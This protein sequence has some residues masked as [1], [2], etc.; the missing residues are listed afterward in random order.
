MNSKIP[1]IFSIDVEEWFHIMEHPAVPGIERWDS[2]Q[3]TL[4]K[5]FNMLLDLCGKHDTAGTCFFL[6]WAARKYPHLVKEA[7]RRGFEVA[8][9]GNNHR[10]I[11]KQTPGEFFEDISSAKKFLEDLTGKTV[12]GYR[13]PGFS[14]TNRTEWAFEKIVEAG[15][16]YDSSV[17]PASRGHGGYI[18][19][20]LGPHR[21][22]TASGDLIEIPISVAGVMGKRV[23]FFGGGYFRLFPYR[24]IKRMTQAI[25]NENRP[26]VFY[27][28]PREIDP[29]HPRLKL[30]VVRNFKSYVNLKKTGVKVEKLLTDF[31]FC[32]FKEWID[33]YFING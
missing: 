6:G 1:N 19:D 16:T 20:N 2:L 31:R 5:S 8:S 24:I 17:F 18:T 15:F 9:H 26:A 12:Y 7:G 33:N 13:A 21:I 14:I 4:E 3:P 30:G 29:G 10:A 27:I 23:C 25:N 28:H 11:Y 32:P 22:K